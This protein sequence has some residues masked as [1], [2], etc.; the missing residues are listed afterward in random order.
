MSV[1]EINLIFTKEKYP[2]GKKGCL[3][4]INKE[5]VDLEF[6]EEHIFKTVMQ[7]HTNCEMLTF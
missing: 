4:Y 7:L 1:F 5:K 6:Q 3:L 2:G